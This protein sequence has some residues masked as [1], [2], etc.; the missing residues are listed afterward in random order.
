[1]NFGAVAN[2]A[3][4]EWTKTQTGAKGNATQ[5]QTVDDYGLTGLQ[6]VS[7]GDL[8]MILLGSTA[9][10]SVLEAY[11]LITGNAE[12]G[13]RPREWRTGV[14][15]KE[16]I[17]CKSNLEGL[18]FDAIFSTTTSH[19]ATV[20]SHPVQSGSKIADHMY[21]EPVS[22]SLEIGMS[23]VMA[24]M[25]R[26]QWSEGNTKSVSCYKK[27]CELQ[28]AR[29]PLTILTRL[30]RYENMVITGITVNDTADTLTGLSAD[31]ELQQILIAN[32]GT[33]KTSARAWTTGGGGGNTD[34]QPKELDPKERQST[35]V[36]LGMEGRL[37]S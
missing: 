11:D 3:A 18:F 36:Q 25:V 37:G 16:L 30:D 27:L 14:S 4:K 20:T 17:Y 13:Y 7:Y 5:G 10:L 32:V 19:T 34:V 6:N 15:D 2:F 24:S 9:G 8:S 23:D 22:I 31:I 21:L 35:M 26:G 12:K 33:E 1:M 28:A 29:M